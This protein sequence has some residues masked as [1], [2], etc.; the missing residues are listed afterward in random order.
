MPD[1]SIS[2]I[3]GDAITTHHVNLLRVAAD[4]RV[5]VLR[6]LERLA[7]G[8]ADEIAAAPETGGIIKKART[9]A[10]L[11][12]TRAMIDEAYATIGDNHGKE[13]A[14]IAGIE[15]TKTA[16]TYDGAIGVHVMTV[17]STKQEL[18]AL[19]SNTLINGRFAR[20]WWAKQSQDTKDRYTAAVRMGAYQGEGVDAI[21]R[22]VRGTA[23]MN[24]QDG[25][26]TLSKAQA[27]ALVRTSV[28][29]VANEAK[30]NSFEEN[31]DIIKAVQWVST[32]DSRTTEICIAL[33]GKQWALPDYEPI[34]HSIPFP[35]PTA[36][37]NC[38]STQI[39]VTKSWAELAWPKAVK[40]PKVDPT[41]I[42]TLFRKNLAKQGF[43]AAE[44]EK[45]VAEKKFQL[46]GSPAPRQSMTEF[47]RK[48]TKLFQDELLG[49][50]KAQMWREGKISLTD[51][52]D[53][54]HR[55]LTAAELQGMV[56]RN[57]VTAGSTFVEGQHGISLMERRLLEESLVHGSQ[58]GGVLTHYVEP[59]TG[60]RISFN[61]TSPTTGDLAV[62]HK[63]DDV[64][65]LR[66]AIA[67][68]EL[69]G[70]QELGLFADLQNFS[71]ARI[72]TPDGKVVSIAV[73]EGEKFTRRDAA[74]INT[75][76]ASVTNK[77]PAAA[78]RKAVA[79]NGKLSVSETNPHAIV[80][81]ARMYARPETELAVR[82]LPAAAKHVYETA[83]ANEPK[84]T[85]ALKTIAKE[86]G[87]EM[88][89]LDFRLKTQE[90]LARKI[91][92]DARE[93]GISIGDA[94]G[95]ISDALRYTAVFPFDTYTAGVK[96]MLADL[97][98]SGLK[99]ERVK[100]FWDGNSYEGINAKLRTKDGMAVELQFHTAQTLDIKEKKSHAIYELM[101][102]TTDPALLKKYNQDLIDVWKDAQMPKGVRTI[103]N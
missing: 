72:V 103:G 7:K 92:N 24:Y 35:G 101:R 68:G 67:K 31:P 46:D 66:N 51:L 58:Q 57:Q 59:A 34:G 52:I 37:W 60:K 36:H 73:R 62:A 18:E 45:I 54:T 28:L 53:Q 26:M 95:Q 96:S 47:L 88:A 82:D 15:Q 6:E 78:F 33:D 22:R 12:H 83:Q 50:Q 44:I 42:E 4:L 11:R 38:R 13:L 70:P 23:A 87:G 5:P 10:L 77:G 39:A 71:G 100:N 93:K 94:A 21:V 69:F 20:E 102:V 17:G 86:H 25:I 81:P 79:D 99:V 14:K 80:P 76:L 30:L 29:A 65:A 56:A 48:Q 2:Q 49:P 40:P 32:L 16:K 55:P 84:V 9:E 41:D 63:F 91:G 98:T 19:A 27:E 43:D 74:E 97:E 1:A 90:S 75:R 3:V 61:G 89:G 8:L 85:G 64:T